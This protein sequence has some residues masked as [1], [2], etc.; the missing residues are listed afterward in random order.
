MQL[1]ISR[2]LDLTPD[3]EFKKT[4][5]VEVDKSWKKIYQEFGR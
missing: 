5:S 3:Q 2:L 1:E 4:E